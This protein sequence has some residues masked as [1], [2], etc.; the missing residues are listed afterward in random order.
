MNKPSEGKKKEIKLQ[1]NIKMGELSDDF[2]DRV[3]NCVRREIEEW[4][5]LES[6]NFRN[7]VVEVKITMKQSLI[8]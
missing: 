8:E 5:S 6:I 1:S 3:A 7:S 4:V 2:S